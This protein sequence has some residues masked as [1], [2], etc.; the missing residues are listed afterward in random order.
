MLHSHIK[1]KIIFYVLLF[2]TAVAVLLYFLISNTSFLE[3][4]LL[5]HCIGLS[6]LLANIFIP[7]KQLKNPIIIILHS[8]VGFFIGLLVG[9]VLHQ[10]LF[11]IKIHFELLLYTGIFFSLLGTIIFWLYLNYS[12]SIEDLE[13]IKK[14]LTLVNYN[15]DKYLHWIKASD[16]KGTYLINVKDVY[17]FQSQ[18][19]YTSVLTKG[20]EYL[21]S[22]P[23]KELTTQL[24]PNIFWQIHRSSIVNLNFIDKISK[25]QNDKL[26]ITIKDTNAKLIISRSFIHLFK[27]M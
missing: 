27:K 8:T 4:L 15:K 13:V 22:T 20:K 6:V 9:F 26:T 16:S 17:Y 24:D 12:K 7:N 14:K 10:M 18:Q 11:Q 1:K 19:K 2:N 3:I 21:I 5:S 23:I 25:N